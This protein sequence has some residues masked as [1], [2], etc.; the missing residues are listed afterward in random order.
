MTS[1]KKLSQELS[2]KVVA[3]EKHIDEMTSLDAMSGALTSD[4]AKDILTAF[5]DRSRNRAELMLLIRV[6]SKL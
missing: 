3:L 5:A 6:L 1:Y 4:E 2:E